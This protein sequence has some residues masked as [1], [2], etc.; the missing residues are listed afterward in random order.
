M[1][2]PDFLRVFD[3]HQPAC[4]DSIQ[5]VQATLEKPPKLEIIEFEGNPAQYP[6]FIA[7]IREA[8]QVH[9]DIK[10]ISRPGS[11]EKHLMP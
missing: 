6:F 3:E 2:G 1:P 10:T 9:I 4:C 8:R 11:K 7:Q 5:P